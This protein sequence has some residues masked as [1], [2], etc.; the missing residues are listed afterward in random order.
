MSYDG[1]RQARIWGLERQPI[2]L[3][4][5]LC[6]RHRF[7]VEAD[8]PQREPARDWSRNTGNHGSVINPL[9][10][11]RHQRFSGAAKAARA[12]AVASPLA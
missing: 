6:R 10:T 9:D 11:V 5:M 3:N 12:K 1:D 7:A 8:R 4:G 2:G